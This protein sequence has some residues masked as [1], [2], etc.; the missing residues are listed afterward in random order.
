MTRRIDSRRAFLA[1]TLAAACRRKPAAEPLPDMGALSDF[2][3]LDAAGKPF[4]RSQLSGKVWV[5]DFIFTR[6]QSVCPRMST[7]MRA[8]QEQLRA[9]PQARLLSITIDPD[10]DTPAV[11]A[12]Y[13]ARYHADPTRWSF[14]TGGKDTIRAL[15]VNAQRHLDPEEITAHSK[16][17]Y[18]L[19]GEGF[20]RGVYSISQ[21]GAAAGL[22]H[23]LRRLIAGPARPEPGVS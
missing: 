22:L 12:A 20:I 5:M 13:A 4:S 3:L 1:V 9:V 14:V 15:Q 17:L 6:C 16:Q 8:I 11:L 7:E 21:P 10:H 18:L 19:D 2:T 23:D